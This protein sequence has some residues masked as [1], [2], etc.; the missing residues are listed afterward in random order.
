MLR[1]LR[2]VLRQH[3]F[4]YSLPLPFP[5]YKPRASVAYTIV[6]SAFNF[7]RVRTCLRT[8]TY[9]FHVFIRKADYFRHA[10]KFSDKKRGRYTDNDSDRLTLSSLTNVSLEI[11]RSLN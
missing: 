8:R 4:F 5:S 6:I 10:V 2:Q 9:T 1:S 3:R 7:A 11:Q